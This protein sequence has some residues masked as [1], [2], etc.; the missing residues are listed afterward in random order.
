M[1]VKDPALWS[2]FVATFPQFMHNFCSYKK[3][4]DYILKILND[5]E[6][7]NILLYSAVGFP[8]NLLW[9]VV[10]TKH[11]GQFTKKECT[12]EKSVT[13]Y[14]TPYFFEIDFQ[15]PNN[16]RE[17]ETIQSLLKTIISTSPIHAPRHVIVC[18]NIDAVANAYAFRVLLERFS[19]NA[20]FVCHTHA[21]ANIETPLRSRFLEVRVPLF[22]IDEIKHI[23]RE[24]GAEPVTNER[25]IF[26]ALV[27]KEFVATFSL[28][29][30][31]RPTI[32]E[33]RDFSNRICNNNISFRL[34][35][36]EL[37]KRIPESRKHAFVQKAA[38][39]EH[40][41]IQTNLG[42]KPLYYELLFHVAFFSKN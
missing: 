22:S 18:R 30:G 9:N 1:K 25:N 35:V 41:M 19:K 27:N 4:V 7:P 3:I 14:E 28:P 17:L 2:K 13:Y 16:S 36:T 6:H 23:F 29:S 40:R 8:L 26:K 12:F 32:L 10:A 38:E 33:I 21:L 42:R 11:W 20:T 24:L 5:D 37:L 31:P 39:I 34:L 15:H